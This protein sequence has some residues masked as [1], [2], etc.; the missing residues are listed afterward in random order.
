MAFECQLCGNSVRNE[1]RDRHKN[2]HEKKRGA[3]EVNKIFIRAKKKKP[4][5]V[6]QQ[7]IDPIQVV[8]DVNINT[9]IQ[10]FNDFNVNT[11]PADFDFDVD[12]MPDDFDDNRDF[13][14]FDPPLPSFFL[15]NTGNIKEFVVPDPDEEPITLDKA[16]EEIHTIFQNNNIGQVAIDQIV[17]WYNNQK[18]ESKFFFV[19]SNNNNYV[20]NLIL[21]RSN[22]S[23]Y[24]S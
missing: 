5:P 20:I 6:F 12:T 17:N 11:M 19:Y 24:L 14:E 15:N 22:I 8:Q 10:N 9:T 1:D 21:F 2:S 13:S 4:A 18:S 7:N 16:N 3:D 23:S